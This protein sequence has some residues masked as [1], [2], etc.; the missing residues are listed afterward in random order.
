MFTARTPEFEVIQSGQGNTREEIACFLETNGLGI[1]DDIAQFVIAR[2][3][4]KLI[5]CAGI[6]GNT[7]KMHCYRYRVAGDFTKPD[8][9]A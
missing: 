6:A 7:F 8:V 9:T 2:Y 1:D 4:R 5:A 3:Q